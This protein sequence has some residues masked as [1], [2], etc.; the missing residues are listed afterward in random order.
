MTSPSCSIA[1][2]RVSTAEQALT[3]HSLQRQEQNAF[4]AAEELGSPIIKT[5]SL[6]QSSRAGKNFKRQDLNEMV[7]LCKTNKKIRYLIVDEVDRFM[8]DIKYFYYFEAVFEQLG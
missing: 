4:K 6:D 7:A 3:G 8:R 2:C 5:W 1:L